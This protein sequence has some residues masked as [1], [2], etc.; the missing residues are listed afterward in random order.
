[1]FTPLE[2]FPLVARCE[3]SVTKEL[4][5]LGRRLQWELRIDGARVDEERDFGSLKISLY[6]K[7][8]ARRSQS[9]RNKNA[10]QPR[11]PQ[12]SSAERGA[13]LPLP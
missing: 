1:M 11:G 4:V 13:T 12:V 8:S 9:A 3:L 10:R 2:V 7:I 6:S 5:G